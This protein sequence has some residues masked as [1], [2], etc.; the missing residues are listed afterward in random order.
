MHCDTSPRFVD[1]STG[2]P[3]AGAVLPAAAVAAAPA[4]DVLSGE[5]VTG[6][7]AAGAGNN[8]NI[9]DEISKLLAT[10]AVV[11]D[12]A[13]TFEQK[14]EPLFMSE[15][16]KSHEDD[17]LDQIADAVKANPSQPEDSFDAKLDTLEAAKVKE[18][19]LDDKLSIELRGIV[20]QIQVKFNQLEKLE[21]AKA[22]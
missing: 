4:E 18:A 20:Q 5:R 12:K 11:E 10:E 17:V 21:A 3:A 2:D 16:K 7:A 22:A 8:V 9:D 1:S 19:A 15:T 6:E 13:K 14:G